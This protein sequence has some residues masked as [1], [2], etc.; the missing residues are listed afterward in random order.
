MS[1]AIS[2]L[3]VPCETETHY[4]EINESF[5]EALSMILASRQFEVQLLE[6]TITRWDETDRLRMG[7]RSALRSDLQPILDREDRSKKENFCSIDLLIRLIN[8]AFQENTR[9]GIHYRQ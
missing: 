5:N 2:R 3:L 4:L 9:R 1:D 7:G 8:E 6:E